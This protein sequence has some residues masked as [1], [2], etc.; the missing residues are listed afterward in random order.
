[1]RGCLSTRPLRCE[2]ASLIMVVL[3]V[4][5]AASI[6]GAVSPCCHAYICK[7]ALLH[8]GVAALCGL[9]ALKDT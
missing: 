2:Q 9:L 6:H 3:A 1:M 5:C 4:A 8:E 7:Y